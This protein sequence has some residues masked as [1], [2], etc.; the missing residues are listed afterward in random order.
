MDA[1]FRAFLRR[2]IRPRLLALCAVAW[3]LWSV[4]RSGPARDLVW[5][6]QALME[7]VEA[8]LR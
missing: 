3:L 1:D 7:D 8:A 2:W 5:Q 6:T 4:D